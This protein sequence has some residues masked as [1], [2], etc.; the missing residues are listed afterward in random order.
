MK[1]HRHRAFLLLSLLLPLGLL[2]GTSMA[3]HPSVA[4]SQGVAG[5]IVTVSAIPLPERSLFFDLRLEAIEFGD[6]SEEELEREGTHSVDRLLSHSLAAAYGATE[7]LTV[8]L[9]LPYLRREKIVEGHGHGGEEEGE[10][11]T[12]ELG[13]AE[14]MGDLTLFGHYRFL[15]RPQEGIHAAFF[16]GLK[17][18]T[19]VDDRRSDEGTRFEAEHQPGSGSWDPMAGIAVTKHLGSLCYDAN[20]LYIVATEGSQET[21]LGDRLTCNAAFSWRIPGSDH[22]HAGERSHFHPAW[23]LIVEA[24]GEYRQ[25]E[26]VDGEEDENTGGSVIYLSPG[27]RY[28]GGGF[29][30]SLSVG[31]PVV[32]DLNGTQSEPQLR[33]ILALGA[34]F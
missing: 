9:R 13:D 30:A 1:N 18:P 15:H 6:L 3:D 26:K 24:N 21:D 27:V 20:V 28:S 10:G 2:P 23:D 4:F 17:A 33:T 12:V 25:K 7:N 34:A 29:S 14:G 31:L 32:T 19:G 16:F 8:G 11:G 22:P 5:P